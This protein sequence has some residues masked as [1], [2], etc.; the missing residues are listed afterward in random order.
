MRVFLD[1]DGVLVNFNKGTFEA[2]GLNYDYHHPALNEWCY[3]K[4]FGISFEKFNAV[5]D[6]NFWA[7]L[8]WMHDGKQILDE[9]AS[10]FGNIY[11]LTTPMPHPGSGTGK[12][13]WIEKHLPRYA[14]RTIIT[15]ASKHILAGPDCLL[16]DDKD[17]NVSE[18]VAAGGMGILVPRPWNELRSWADDTLE[19]VKNNLEKC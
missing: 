13:L 9:I 14:K 6:I 7:N 18:F 16:I 10:R 4:Y 5:C 2:F 17:E 12:I 1:M 3:Y 11:L 19:V 15:Q 8:E